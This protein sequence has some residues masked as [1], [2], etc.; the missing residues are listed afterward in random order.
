[1]LKKDVAV[2]SHITADI[3]N[4]FDTCYG[5]SNI[6]QK[7]SFYE[8]YRKQA[9]IARSLEY[10]ELKIQGNIYMINFKRITNTRKN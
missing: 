8:S 5:A 10:G 7:P 3:L 4:G 2:R 9:G 1:M 6:G